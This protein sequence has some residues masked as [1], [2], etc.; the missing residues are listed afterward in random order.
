MATITSTGLG[1]GIDVN[2]IVPKLVTA[3]R[4]A[5]DTRL[6]KQEATLQAKL[7]SWGTVKGAFSD[8]KSSLLSLKLPSTFQKV[9]ATSSDSSALGVTA[10]SNADLGQYRMEVKQLAQSHSLASKSFANATDV[11][12]TGTL[13]IRLGTTDYDPDTDTYNGFSQNPDKGSKS[14]II[15]SSNNTL[16]G[17]RDA[18]NKANIGVSASL[19]ND[20]GGYRLVLNTTEGGA[21]NSVQISA[22]DSDGNHT[23]LNGL[24]ALAF[25]AGA[26]NMQQ[27]LAAQDARLTINGLDV[28][29]SSNTITTALKGVTL[30]LNQAQPGKVIQ[31]G[32]NQ[33]TSAAVSGLENFVAKF[34]ELNK[35][36]NSVA[37]YDAKTKTAGVLQGDALVRGAMSQVRAQLNAS[38]PGLSGTVR[39][40][41]DI[42]IKTEDDGSLAF[43]TA[44]FTSALTKDREGVMALF[45]QQGRTTDSGVSYLSSGDD[46]QVG[47]YAVEIT[48][49]ATRGDF[50]GGTLSTLTV[51]ASNDRFRIN[52]DGKESGLITLSQ[53][54]YTT[55][56]LLTELQSRINGDSALSAAGVG[57]DV[58][59]N[60]TENRLE[61]T[62]RNYGSTTGVA[63]LD[64]VGTGLGLDNGQYHQG[65]D[66]AGTIGGFAATG[67]GQEL[68]A[69][70]GAAKGL[71]VAVESGGTGDRGTVSFSR[72][73][74]D[75][76]DTLLNGL[77]KNNG[78]IS[79]RTDGLQR[80]LSQIEKDR[81][82]LNLKMEK[83]EA[84]LFS[85]FNA[86]D[87]VVAKLQST[88]TY[89]TQQLSN[90]PYANM[91]SD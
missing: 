55:E 22:A 37:G 18:I 9:A 85:Q 82:T 4:K 10:A 80:N 41:S 67:A 47:S 39:S 34:N 20:G 16:T 52:V 54:D 25:N 23:D 77:V 43:D 61:I 49:M 65:L 26:T 21:N 51:D 24:S 3:E 53:G 28:N 14:L 7:S 32:I 48:Q 68:T 70:E 36:V 87:L 83:Y 27:T 90:L 64:V 42:G 44:K 45:T 40:L 50:I 76:L 57:V 8:L 59:F 46:S 62:S 29:S 15:D 30:N 79:S 81:E 5:M 89:L 1:S 11:V 69:T 38:I 74:M 35:T 60:A 84:R 63:L 72:G 88:S 2:S 91:N 56:T 12:G 31:V 71:S 6:D 86:M 78:S 66:V 19:V 75:G 58:A 17:V 73:L 33:D 13:T